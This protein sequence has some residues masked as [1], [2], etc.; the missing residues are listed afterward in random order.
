MFD[1]TAAQQIANF[2]TI[3]RLTFAGFDVLIFDDSAGL[4][5]HHDFGTRFHFVS[6]Y[7]GHSVLSKIA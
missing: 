3:E 6:A 7:T 4:S 2:D 1:N 5:I